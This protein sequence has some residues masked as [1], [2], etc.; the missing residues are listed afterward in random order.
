ML[1]YALKTTAI[2]ALLGLGV[3]GAVSTGASAD[4]IRTRC[5]GDDC[6]RLRCND[7]GFDCVRTGYFDR[8]DYDRVQPYGYTRAYD[9]YPDATTTYVAPPAPVYDYDYHYDDDY[10]G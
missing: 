10:P 3:A 2:A 4:T 5:Y 7:L 6:V 1:A 8:G 9:Y